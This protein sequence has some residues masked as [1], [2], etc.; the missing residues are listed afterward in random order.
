MF[1]WPCI[2][3]SYVQNKQ[4]DAANIQNLFCHK[5]VHVSGICAYHQELPAVRM[6][7]GTF[8]AGYVAAA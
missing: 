5:T 8:H 3:T 4:L 6:T 7:I 1:K 2:V